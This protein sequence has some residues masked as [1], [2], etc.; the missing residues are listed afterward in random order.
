MKSPAGYFNGMNE[1]RM[2]EILELLPPD[3]AVT[4]PAR[5]VLY[6]LAP[7]FPARIS[8]SALQKLLIYSSPFEVSV[9]DWTEQYPMASQ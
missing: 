1:K 7:A 6:N 2:D 3:T 5:Q 9:A 8:V 4:L